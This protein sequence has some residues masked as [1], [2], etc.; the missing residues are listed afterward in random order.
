MFCR[1]ELKARFPIMDA[2]SAALSPRRCA[3]ASESRETSCLVRTS[4]FGPMMESRSRRDHSCSTAAF[5]RNPEGAGIVSSPSWYRSTVMDRRCGSK[6]EYA[7]WLALCSALN[8]ALVR[9]LTLAYGS[10]ESGGNDS[11]FC[12]LCRYRSSSSCIRSARANDLASSA[13]S[14]SR[15]AL[16]IAACSV[17]LIVSLLTASASP[18]ESSSLARKAC[19]ICSSSSAETC[20]VLGSS[21]CDWCGFA[22]AVEGSGVC[23][24]LVGSGKSIP[25]SAN[26]IDSSSSA[27]KN[28]AASSKVMSVAPAAG[29]VVAETG[30]AANP[31]IPETTDA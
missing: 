12:R 3:L 17:S 8:S 27:D 25:P 4:S 5:I 13:A 22:D 2:S 10:V 29:G 19:C 7:P 30:A 15:I 9:V 21:I 31:S 23:V 1:N 11:C 28:L 14:A 24:E 6:P 20:D 26:R 18:F 16:S